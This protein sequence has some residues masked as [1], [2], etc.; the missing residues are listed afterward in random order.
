MNSKERVQAAIYFKSPDKIP[1]FNVLK[2]DIAPLPIGNAKS[3]KPG[4]IEREIGLF[5]YGISPIHWDRPEWVENNPEFEGLKW[6]KIPHEEVDEWGRIWN[7]RGGDID[8]G[9]PGR[10]TITNIAELDKYLDTYKLDPSDISRYKPSLGLKKEYDEELYHLVHLK[11]PGPCQLVSGLLGFSNFLIYHKRHPNELKELLYRVTEFHV[12]T[13]NYSHKYGLNPDGFWLTDD[14]G[15]QNGPYFSP[16]VFKSF[17]KDAY[18]PIFDKAHEYGTEVHMHSCGKIDR[19]LPYL[20]EWGLDAIEMDSPRMS[21]YPELAPYR[22]KIMFWGCVNIQ[23][24]YVNSLP[25]EVERE[26]W[27]MIRNLGTPNGGYGAYFYPTPK[28][29]KT[30]R[31]NIKAFQR[32]IEKFGDYAKIPSHWWDYPINKEWDDNE[33]PDLPQIEE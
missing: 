10:A 23:S 15:E 22:G 32:G 12:K 27:H 31:K 20:I 28:V 6:K 19:L 11:D 4:W 16:R 26:V 18:K 7:F 5:P 1:V 33:V 24:I 21:G 14:L 9:H 8:K 29:L 3:W 2:G 17:Y 13:I 30:P 25:E